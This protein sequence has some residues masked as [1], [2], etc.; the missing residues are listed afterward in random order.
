MVNDRDI[1]MIIVFVAS[2]TCRRTLF[3]RA[4][5]NVG[6]EERLLLDQNGRSGSALDANEVDRSIGAQGGKPW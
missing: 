2:L 6:S 3:R 1:P 4:E 5:A